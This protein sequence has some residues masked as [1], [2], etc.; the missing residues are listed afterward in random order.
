M[1][2]RLEQERIRREQKKAEKLR[3]DAESSAADRPARRSNGEI[4]TREILTPEPKVP[5]AATAVVARHHSTPSS[6]PAITAAA[7]DTSTSAEV[8][9]KAKDRFAKQMSAVIVKT[10]DP[11]RAKGCKGHIKSSEDFKHLAKKVS[12]VSVLGC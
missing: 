3:R 7:A 4:S 8:E 1:A 11:F 6:R 12:V 2:D 9:K 5:P 10:L